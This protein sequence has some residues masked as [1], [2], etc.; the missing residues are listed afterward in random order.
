[1]QISSKNFLNN[2]VTPTV[3]ILFMLEL[4]ESQDETKKKNIANPPSSV[5]TIRSFGYG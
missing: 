1:M 2:S 3:V 4:K 5:K